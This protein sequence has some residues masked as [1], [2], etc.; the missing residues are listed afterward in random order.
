MI[1]LRM[2]GD[3]LLT[4][5]AV[6]TV[7]RSFPD[8]HITYL[9]GRPASDVL[10][11]NPDVD[12]IF[13]YDRSVFQKL[14]GTEPYDLTINFDGG[15]IP[16]AICALS[17]ARYRI[18]IN[19]EGG[20]QLKNVYNVSKIKPTRNQN[21][22]DSFLN[23]TRSIGLKDLTTKTRFYL[24]KEEKDFSKMYLKEHNLD[25]QNIIGI[26]PGGHGKKSLWG[27]EKFA[28]LSDEMVKNFSSTILIFQG[29]GEE[30]IATDVY[31]RMKQK[32]R[33]LLVPI[34]PLRKYAS[35]VNRCGI[36]I[37]HD[38]GPIH[39]SASLRVKTIGIFTSPQASYW[40]PYQERN[41]CAYL[42]KDSV[43]DIT[44]QDVL[45]VCTKLL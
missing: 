33:V 41:G 45:N 21:V 5:P 31:S 7:R 32:H 16:D 18:G 39:I 17:A 42:Q 35:L 20:L 6:Y 9:T 13:V 14:V 10:L 12:E 3:V 27:A 24:T 28:K 34:L 40:F 19:E 43:N 38:R 2:I 22:I 26:H 1:R 15:E 30:D 4:T 23:L 37:A 11:N 8:A 44:V 29:P 25:Q 36:L